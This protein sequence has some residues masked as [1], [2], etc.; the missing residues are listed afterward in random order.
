MKTHSLKIY[1]LKMFT[2]CVLWNLIHN[3]WFIKIY[4]FN[5]N[6]FWANSGLQ[7][8]LKQVKLFMQQL[9]FKVNK[10]LKQKESLLSFYKE[11]LT[12]SWTEWDCRQKKEL[13][14][15]LIKKKE[16]LF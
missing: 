3:N 1:A 2:E 14:K 6:K 8:S 10:I 12:I 5:V 16:N 11:L 4:I 15:L 13:Y 9:S 7:S